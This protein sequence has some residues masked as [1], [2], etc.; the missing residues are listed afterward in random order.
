MRPRAR[1]LVLALAAG[2]GCGPGAGPPHA[3]PA[4]NVLASARWDDGRAEYSTYS[5]VTPQG[6]QER[7]TTASLIVVKEDLLRASLVKSDSGSIPGRTVTAIKCNF[8]S[9]FSAGTYGEHDMATVM[10]ERSS[11]RAIKETASHTDGCGITFVRVGPVNGTM[12]QQ[13]HSY[14]QGEADRE[15]RIEIPAAGL[16]FEDALPVWLRRWAG[17]GGFPAELEVWM[18]PGQ[19]GARAPIAAARPV[20]AV[21]RRA[22]GDTLVTP[23]G[24]FPT[25]RFSIQSPDGHSR[26]WLAA[27]DPHLLV[28]VERPSGAWLELHH[29]VR[30]DYW[31]H[32]R[33]GDERLVGEANPG[34]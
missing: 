17:S 18:L 23:A 8:I 14:W 20:R 19:L 16:V 4:G 10:L 12:T 24:R 3:A 6:G 11:G 25:V 22:A 21:I 26:Y 30:I 5:G 7:R 27:A 2:T 33:N 15:T 32:T 31:N 1:A 28:R 9:D 34:P 29:S 13:A